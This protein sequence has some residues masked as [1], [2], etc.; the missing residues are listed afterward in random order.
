M[1]KDLIMTYFTTKRAFNRK[2]GSANLE[3]QNVICKCF[4][5]VLIKNIT[6][7]YQ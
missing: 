7:S 6:Q 1:S 3:N 5:N 2:N 4:G